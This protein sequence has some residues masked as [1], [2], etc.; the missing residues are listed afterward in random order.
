MIDPQAL[1]VQPAP[2]FNLL[3]GRPRLWKQSANRVENIPA[4][5]PP[6]PTGAVR[7][8]ALP[9]FAGP[10]SWLGRLRARIVW[11]RAARADRRRRRALGEGLRGRTSWGGSAA[12]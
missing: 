8:S 9:F 11:T 10:A 12:A 5:I 4:F 2:G 1:F 3:T 7:L 6:R